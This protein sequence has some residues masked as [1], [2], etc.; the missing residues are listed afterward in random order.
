MP[1]MI[2]K[3][4]GFRRLGEGPVFGG[5]VVGGSQ[6][7]ARLVAG[8]H[9][10]RLVAMSAAS[11]AASSSPAV[12]AQPLRVRNSV[13]AASTSA[14]VRSGRTTVQLDRYV[15]TSRRARWRR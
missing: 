8:C 11:S 9:D 7:G 13:A 14:T 4:G 12:A 3:S 1:P 2:L 10:H 6:L 15:E 5:R